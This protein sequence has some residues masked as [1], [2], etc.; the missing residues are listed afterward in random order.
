CLF[1]CLP[2]LPY[3]PLFPYTTLFRSVVVLHEH[4][5]VRC[6]PGSRTGPQR[7]AAGGCRLY[8]EDT[9]G[10]QV[11][12]G[13]ALGGHL[14]EEVSVGVFELAA[15]RALV[16]GV[17]LDDGCF[18]VVLFH[19]DAAVGLQGLLSQ[20]T[21][22]A[23]ASVRCHDRVADDHDEKDGR[24]RGTDDEE[25]LL[26]L[27]CP[28]F[29][30]SFLPDPCA[31]TFARFTPHFFLCFSTSGCDRRPYSTGSAGHRNRPKSRSRAKGDRGRSAM[32]APM[33]A[34]AR[35]RAMEIP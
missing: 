29:P 24:G 9:D 11:D 23:G 28:L 6:G 27:C 21:F 26:A 14:L 31:C 25:G 20:F 32:K 12:D 2:P 22:V 8:G 34:K 30:F 10:A 4:V 13:L 15:G 18:C 3:S 35:S 33:A 7:V 16:V 5:V 1:V 19:D 17:D